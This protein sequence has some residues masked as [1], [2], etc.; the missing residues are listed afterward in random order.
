MVVPF[1]DNILYQPSV[2]SINGKLDDKEFE[3]NHDMCLSFKKN[4]KTICAK[5]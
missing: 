5:N 4:R 3:P 1:A 2:I